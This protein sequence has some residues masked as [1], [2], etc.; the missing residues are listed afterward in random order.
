MG[1]WIQ[2]SGE[3]SQELW[4]MMDLEVLPESRTGPLWR[5]MLCCQCEGHH[6]YVPFRTSDKIYSNQL[7]VPFVSLPF[8]LENLLWLSFCYLNISCLGVRRASH[9]TFFFRGFWVLNNYMIID[10]MAVDFEV[11]ISWMRLLGM[12]VICI[13]KKVKQRTIYHE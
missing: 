11:G 8:E 12:N 5:T 7:Y 3:K 10:F 13:V 6:C 9:S 1:G 4:E 2:E